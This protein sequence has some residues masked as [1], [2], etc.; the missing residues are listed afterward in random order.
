MAFVVVIKSKASNATEKRYLESCLEKTYDGA[1]LV[2]W[3]YHR[4]YFFASFLV[5]ENDNDN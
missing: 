3:K 5:E 4:E 1:T 2:R